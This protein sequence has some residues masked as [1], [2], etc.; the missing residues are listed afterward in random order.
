M[1]FI[2]D[3]SLTSS[4]SNVLVVTIRKFLK[5]TS[6]LELDG[7]IICLSVF[8]SERLRKRL[9]TYCVH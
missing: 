7:Y 6:A 9:L 4:G 2:N 8:L 3:D 1:D 5:F